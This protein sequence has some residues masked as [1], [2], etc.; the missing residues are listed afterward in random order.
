MEI[1]LNE[2]GHDKWISW[3]YLLVIINE[4]Y[5]YDGG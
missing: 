2:K 5:P 3:F 1:G 4:G